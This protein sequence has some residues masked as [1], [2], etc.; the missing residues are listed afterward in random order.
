MTYL[1]IT[2]LVVTATWARLAWAIWRLIPDE[3]HW[4]VWCPLHKK[5]AKIAVVQREAE[6]AP[7]CAQ[8]KV[9]DVARCSLFGH[10]EVNCR[11]ECLDRPW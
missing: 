2:I 8:L 6:G 7:G 10:R 1:A 3:L 5:E 11:K 4:T 9:L